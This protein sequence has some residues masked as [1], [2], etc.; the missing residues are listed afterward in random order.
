MDIH[1]QPH[2]RLRL[3]RWRYQANEWANAR[4]EHHSLGSSAHRTILS[5]SSSQ[6]HHPTQRVAYI[7]LR[8]GI[9]HYVS[10]L[11]LPL[12]AHNW[13]LSLQA[14]GQHTSSLNGW[15][16]QG[17]WRVSQLLLSRCPNRGRSHTWHCKRLKLYLLTHSAFSSH[18]RWRLL[19]PHQR[20]L[21]L[22][23]W[24]LVRLLHGYSINGRGPSR[25]DWPH[26]RCLPYSLSWRHGVKHYGTL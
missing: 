26:G 14:W 19:R 5:Y 9:R 1:E 4:Q 2:S 13:F 8:M 21:R 10:S 25:M 20:S 23:R 18:S 3:F 15:R 6:T 16:M 12:P 17:R 11:L 22:L 24:P 7:Y